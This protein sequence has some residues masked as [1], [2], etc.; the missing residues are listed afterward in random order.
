MGYTVYPVDLQRE[1]WEQ[2]NIFNL[3]GSGGTQAFGF[4]HP[5]IAHLHTWS[6]L[7]AAGTSLSTTYTRINLSDRIPSAQSSFQMF[8]DHCCQLQILFI[9]LTL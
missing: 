8:I 2:W 4:T 1:Q 5:A 7:A 6:L 3:T 9:C